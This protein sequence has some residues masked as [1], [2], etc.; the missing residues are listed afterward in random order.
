MVVI[1]GV[2][3]TEK[4]IPDPGCCTEEYRRPLAAR[5]P[6]VELTVYGGLLKDARMVALP[7]AVTENISPAPAIA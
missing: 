1:P 6:G 4:M 7:V 5:A 2:D 3:P